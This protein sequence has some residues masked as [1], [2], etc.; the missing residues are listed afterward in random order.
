MDRPNLPHSESE[1]QR[2]RTPDPHRAHI[3]AAS[4]R[5]RR[6]EARRRQGDR[7][8]C[9]SRARFGDDAP[10][11]STCPEKLALR[12]LSRYSWPRGCTENG[13]GRG[14]VP[15]VRERTPSNLGRSFVSRRTHLDR[16]ALRT[17][18][19]PLDLGISGCGSITNPKST[20]R[21][22]L[23]ASTQYPIATPDAPLKARNR[24]N[25][26]TRIN[27]PRKLRTMAGRPW[28]LER[29]RRVSR[30]RIS[31][32]LRHHRHPAGHCAHCAPLCPSMDAGTV[33]PGS[34]RPTAPL[35]PTAPRMAVG[36][37]T[38]A[39]LEGFSFFFSALTDNGQDT[40][41]K[42]GGVCLRTCPNVS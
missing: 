14:R 6:H 17:V 31:A 12:T 30:P 29:I 5:L 16:L 19:Q 10:T 39:A 3:G 26:S 38:R 15:Q 24:P 21:G 27:S 23:N 28:T 2:R 7:G 37:V 22:T 13:N 1:R 8:Y 4:K 18:W 42:E 9:G 40:P 33:T 32:P 25:R 36:G 41:S 20:S 35:C 11:A 34:V